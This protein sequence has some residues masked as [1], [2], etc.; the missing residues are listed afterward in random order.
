MTKL[1]K[2]E[3]ATYSQ[4]VEADHHLPEYAFVYCGFWG[5]Y[6]W[7]ENLGTTECCY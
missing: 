2:P 6:C 7:G 4:A 5:N 1:H 3:R